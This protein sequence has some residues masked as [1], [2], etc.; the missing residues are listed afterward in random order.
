MYIVDRLEEEFAVVELPGGA[1]ENIPLR[2]LPEGVR[3]GDALQRDGDTGVYVVDPL[4]T[5]IR[6][7]A[8]RKRFKKLFK[9]D[10]KDE[11]V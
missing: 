6:R 11:Y 10:A 7:D 9:K 3:E 4:E 5:Q 8:A 2:L 1:R